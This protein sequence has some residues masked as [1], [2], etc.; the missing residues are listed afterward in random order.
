MHVHP[1]APFNKLGTKHPTFTKMR[2]CS[3]LTNWMCFYTTLRLLQS[4][5][6]FVN[7]LCILQDINLI[8]M[9]AHFAWSCASNNIIIVYLGN[10]DRSR[11]TYNFKWYTILVVRTYM[12]MYN[13]VYLFTTYTLVSLSLSSLFP[14]ST[15]SF[16]STVD[17]SLSCR[18]DCSLSLNL[19]SSSIVWGSREREQHYLLYDSQ[20]SVPVTSAL[21]KYITGP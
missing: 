19:F 11:K 5:H 2:L 8:Q 18:D 17:S 1:S 4:I 12:Y 15:L 20:Y 7:S 16:S 6:S 9:S 10:T 3:I 13:Y 14:P 21:Y